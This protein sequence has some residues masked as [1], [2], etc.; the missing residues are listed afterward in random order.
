M[1]VG[2]EHCRGYVDFSK[3]AKGHKLYFGL[4]LNP[5]N[6]EN[7]TKAEPL[8]IVSTNGTN[9]LFSGHVG[10]RAPHTHKL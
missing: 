7:F 10:S 3:L 9:L 8:S 5:L 6:C 2:F 1:E 4:E